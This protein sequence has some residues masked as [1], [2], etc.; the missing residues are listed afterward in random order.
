[1]PA[2]VVAMAAPTTIFV[3]R[4]LVTTIGSTLEDETMTVSYTLQSVLKGFFLMEPK[5]F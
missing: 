1:M 3:Q 4:E 5:G 2:A